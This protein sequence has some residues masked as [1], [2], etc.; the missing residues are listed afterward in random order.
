MHMLIVEPQLDLVI[1]DVEGRAAWRRH[2]EAEAPDTSFEYLDSQAAL[3][4]LIPDADA[5]GGHVSPEALART[6][7]RLRWI[8]GHSSAARPE[9]GELPG[10]PRARHLLSCCKG[11][12]AIPLAEH[13]MMLML[14]LNRDALRWLRARRSHRWEPRPT[15]S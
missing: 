2:L 9:L 3:I 8:F 1:T 15:P 14:M 4:E 10:L 13:A 6:S 7:D 5:V 12:G 11:N